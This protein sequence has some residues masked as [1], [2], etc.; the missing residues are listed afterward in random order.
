MFTLTYVEL[1]IETSI[2]IWESELI[3]LPSFHLAT[4][5]NSQNTNDIEFNNEFWHINSFLN[6]GNSNWRN[7]SFDHT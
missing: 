2:S 3:V 7:S 1:E 6:I 5:L 4:R